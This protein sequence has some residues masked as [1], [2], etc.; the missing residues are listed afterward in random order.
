MYNDALLWKIF[1]L[2]E[3]LGYTNEYNKSSKTHNE[4]VAIKI[5][6]DFIIQM[7]T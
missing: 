1:I 2:K 5:K 6:S 4:R 3:K 7:H